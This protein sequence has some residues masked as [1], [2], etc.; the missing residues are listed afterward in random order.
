MVKPT[1]KTIEALSLKIKIN[2]PEVLGKIDLSKVDS[3]TKPK[4]LP[5]R[6]LNRCAA[7]RDRLDSGLGWSFNL[8]IK[9]YKTFTQNNGTTKNNA[10]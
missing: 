10:G 3:S 2:E 1:K 5:K 9:N 4:I 8:L 7:L 6:K